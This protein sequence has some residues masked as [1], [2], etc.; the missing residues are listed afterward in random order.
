MIRKLSLILSIAS[1]AILSADEPAKNSDKE[2][3]ELTKQIEQH[4][5]AALNAEIE[6]QT[7]LPVEW[8]RYAEKIRESEKHEEEAKALEKKLSELL[9]QKQSTPNSH[10]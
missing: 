4:R 10:S 1:F 2:I 8:N 9:Q 6:A 5:E 3:T 7:Y